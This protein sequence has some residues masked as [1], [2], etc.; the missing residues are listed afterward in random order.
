MKASSSF[1]VRPRFLPGVFDP[2]HGPM[3]MMLTLTCFEWMYAHAYSE[4]RSTATQPLHSLCW[5]TALLS[6]PIRGQQC[7]PAYLVVFRLRTPYTKTILAL[8]HISNKEQLY[9]KIIR[10][11]PQQPAYTPHA[12][13]GHIARRPSQ[14]KQ[15]L[16]FVQTK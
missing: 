6:A 14:H 3:T 2:K 7:E 5:P 4:T 13:R 11:P 8:V 15:G 10:T 1:V 16:D 9:I 12:A